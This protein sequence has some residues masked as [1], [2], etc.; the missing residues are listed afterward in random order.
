MHDFI[1][2]NPNCCIL[3]VNCFVVKFKFCQEICLWC[4][5]SSP[6]FQF[7]PSSLLH[8]VLS[9]SVLPVSVRFC[10]TRSTH[11]SGGGHF[12][13]GNPHGAVHVPSLDYYTSVSLAILHSSIQIEVRVHRYSTSSVLIVDT[14]TTIQKTNILYNLINRRQLRYQVVFSCDVKFKKR[15]GS[16]KNQCLWLS[17]LRVF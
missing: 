9:L 11:L 3:F 17:G 15:S 10:S 5:L 6:H 14:T 7:H 8:S 1:F 13:M 12:K 16:W 4:L 2:V